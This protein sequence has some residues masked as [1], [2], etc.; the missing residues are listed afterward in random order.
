MAEPSVDNAPL[1]GNDTH[2]SIY[3]TWDNTTLP[4]IWDDAAQGRVEVFLTHG[5]PVQHDAHTFSCHSGHGVVVVPEQRN[6]HHWNAVIHGLIDAVQATMTQKGPGVGMTL[7]K[8]WVKDVTFIY[9]KRTE[10]L[11]M[12]VLSIRFLNPVLRTSTVKIH[13]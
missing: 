2:S 13:M 12:S 7:R 3:C 5:F 9:V 10:L 6:T 11:F 8:K 4:L 1:D